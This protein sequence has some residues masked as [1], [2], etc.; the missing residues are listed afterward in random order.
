MYTAM[1]DLELKLGFSDGGDVF[2]FV[3]RNIVPAL[4]GSSTRH[5]V[6]YNILIVPIYVIFFG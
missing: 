1:F 4:S 5:L 3:E 2:L 6:F